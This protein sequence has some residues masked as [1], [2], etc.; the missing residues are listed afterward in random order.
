MADACARPCAPHWCE[1]CGGC[2][3]HDC[4]R[5]DTTVLAHLAWFA[6]FASPGETACG[7]IGGPPH[8]VPATYP[9]DVCLLPA[10]PH[11]WHRSPKGWT[12]PA[13]TTEEPMT[14][15]SGCRHCGIPRRAHGRQVTADGAHT[16]E[17]PTRQQILARMRARAA[18]QEPSR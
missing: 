9:P 16:Y 5:D 6:A 2:P 8:L 12:W 17:P 18:R 14:V 4:R 10:G 1:F 15:P 3:A 11:D 13:T 7:H